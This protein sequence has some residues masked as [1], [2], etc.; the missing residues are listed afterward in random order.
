MLAF[1]QFPQ[2]I[3]VVLTRAYPARKPSVLMQLLSGMGSVRE[4]PGNT[5]ISLLWL[6]SFVTSSASLHLARLQVHM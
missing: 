3:I 2:L 5:C 1:R 6:C 4:C